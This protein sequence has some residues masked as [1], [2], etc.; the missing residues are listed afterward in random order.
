[1]IKEENKSMLILKFSENEIDKINSVEYVIKDFQKINTKLSEKI[2][3]FII[4][5]DNLLERRK[6]EGALP[7]LIS[8]GNFDY[9][10]IFIDNLQ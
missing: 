9:Y 5:I 7:D 6:M 3:I 4:Y 8:F 10:Q 1:M 2:I